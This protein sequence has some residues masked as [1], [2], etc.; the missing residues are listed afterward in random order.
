MLKKFFFQ[1]LTSFM[2]AW[3]AIVLAGVAAVIVMIGIVGS[4][5]SGEDTSIRKDSVLKITLE[6]ALEE[7]DNGT[8]LNILDLMNGEREKVQ[9][10]ETLTSAIKEAQDNGNIKCI[11][12]DCQGIAA[13]PASLNAVRDALINF[14]KSKKKI[15]AYADT[16]TGGDYFLASVADEIV[17]NP[18]GQVQFHGIGG[19]NL[20]FKD[21]FDKIGVEFQAVRVG[22]GK[23]AVEPY[24]SS[25]MSEVAR[26][27]SLELYGTIWKG[28][29][30][31]M[32]EAR[33][34]FTAAQLDTLISV[35]LISCRPAKFILDNKLVTKLEYRHAFEARL[36]KACGQKDGLT[37]VVTPTQLAQQN[38]AGKLQIKTENQVA[39]LY[40]CGGIDMAFS[41]SGINSEELSEQIYELMED[42]NVKALVLRV[43]SPGGSAFGS[44]QIWEALEK[45]KAA[46]KPFIVSMGDYAASGGYYI[47][48]GAQRIFADPYTITGSI[49]IYG[50]I[51]NINGLCQKLGVNPQMVATNP[52]ALFPNMFYAMN[53]QQLAAM[54][55]MVEDGYNLFVKRC[56]DGRKM[57][58]AKLS[59]IADGRPI[60]ATTAKTLG[61]VDEIKPLD[62]AIAYAARQ[63]K[64]KNWN[65]VSYPNPGNP[66]QEL[67]K[68]LEQQQ[69]ALAL[70]N[71]SDP[72]RLAEKVLPMLDRFSGAGALQA[73]M[74]T[75]IFSY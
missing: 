37:N 9:T 74:P 8:S 72:T 59:E 71:E 70:I 28:M 31:R 17:L 29:T 67:M 69:A 12:L 55:S 48:C 19:I 32:A 65:V 21:L 35:D 30:T 64:L 47:S 16:Y 2:G 26:Q 43:N 34:G 50:L 40:A 3:L 58:V 22:K 10:V 60:A 63:A 4:L 13:A 73:S 11:Y 1:V 39:V 7:R 38:S 57:T 45:F 46:G 44:E 51:P 49:G 20:F 52:Q 53:E 54:Q 75:I 36:A 41:G 15:Y 5:M 25:E 61:L 24:T 62:D 23:A 42:D 14:K 68:Q 33:K 66:L 18:V 6:G 56:A 27:Q